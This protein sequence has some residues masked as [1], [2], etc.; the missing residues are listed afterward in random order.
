MPN[1]FTA[2]MFACRTGYAECAGLLLEAGARPDEIVTPDDE[3]AAERESALHLAAH[4]KPQDPAFNAQVMEALLD[5]LA[6][7]LHG[8]QVR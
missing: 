7:Q 4:M 3:A 8:A 2:L 6:S 5:A 1:G